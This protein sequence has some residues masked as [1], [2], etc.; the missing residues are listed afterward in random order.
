MEHILLDKLR[1]ASHLFLYSLLQFV[2]WFIYVVHSLQLSLIWS[3]TFFIYLLVISFVHICT[4]LRYI[5]SFT[6]SCSIFKILCC[7][8]KVNFPSSGKRKDVFLIVGWTVPFTANC[9]KCI[10]VENMLLLSEHNPYFHLCL[11]EKKNM[12]L[13]DV[14]CR[15][16]PAA[17]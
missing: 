4:I 16:A 17:L 11:S 13:V 5:C 9:I 6:F 12:F 1:V 3:V 14:L 15:S 10:Q 7:C 2:H 8:N